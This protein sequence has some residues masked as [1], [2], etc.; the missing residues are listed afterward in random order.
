VPP[1]IS[2]QA[3]GGSGRATT[4]AAGVHEIVNRACEQLREA[5]GMAQLLSSFQAE[6]RHLKQAHA[7]TSRVSFHYDSPV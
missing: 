5:M 7:D 2:A 3:H 6:Y 1:E 4:G